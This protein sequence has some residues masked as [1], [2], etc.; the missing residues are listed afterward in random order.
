MTRRQHEER[1]GV[2]V[3]LFFAKRSCLD[4]KRFTSRNRARDWAARGNKK[5]ARAQEP[6]RCTLCGGWHLRTV[7]EPEL[8]RA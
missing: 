3:S 5:Y 8:K 7:H 6:Y 2:T 4:K 1:I